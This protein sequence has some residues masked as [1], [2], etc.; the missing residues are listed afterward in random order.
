MNDQLIRSITKE[1]VDKAIPDEIDLWVKVQNQVIHLPRRLSRFSTKTRLWTSIGL[2]AFLFVVLYL[3]LTTSGRAIAQQIRG[4]FTRNVST[5]I[6]LTTP[7][8]Q[9]LELL[10]TPV[11]EFHLPL[12]DTEINSQ[13]SFN[14]SLPNCADVITYETYACK[15]QRAE[16]EAGFEIKEFPYLPPGWSFNS[17]EAYPEDKWVTQQFSAQESLIYFD[18][19]LGEFPVSYFKW[20]SVPR[21]YIEEVAI[22]DISGEYVHGWFFYQK[23][24]DQAIWSSEGGPQ[25]LAWEDGQ[26]WYRITTW[27]QPE[28]A[29][30]LDREELIQLAAKLVDTLVLENEQLPER[31]LSTELAEL[32]AGFDLKVPSKL[33]LGVQ[34]Y[35]ADV[36]TNTSTVT[37]VFGG[38]ASLVLRESLAAIENSSNLKIVDETAKP[39]RVVDDFGYLISHPDEKLAP[40]KLGGS[41]AMFYLTWEYNNIIFEMIYYKYDLFGGIIGEKDMIEIAESMRDGYMVH[42]VTLET[43]YSWLSEFEK[44]LEMDIRELSSDQDDIQFV[45]VEGFP[46]EKYVVSVYKDVISGGK[47]F[48]YQG[49]GQSIHAAE[50]ERV[51]D[52]FRTEVFVGVP[53]DMAWGNLVGDRWVE[54]APYLRIRWT[55]GNQWF[56][57]IAAQVPNDELERQRLIHQVQFAR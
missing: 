38:D 52:N 46:N 14:F 26:R 42:G 6:P 40:V 45:G 13:N 29:G 16:R 53:A 50:W 35:Y 2:A 49:I 4:L 8:Q 54:T 51:P 34:F 55:D 27:L 56:E 30:Y 5:V 44:L 36:D 31:I 11:P 47:L 24:Q 57:L 39:I 22:N 33:P 21:D 18:Q 43:P 1:I 41:S 25:R 3:S 15:I 37:L 48:L 10:G 7:E 12:V 9:Q 17:V 32:L 19:G 20:E 23:G 28:N